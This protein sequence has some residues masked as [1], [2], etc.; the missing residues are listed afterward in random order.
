MTR[1]LD[2]P[3]SPAVPSTGGQIIEIAPVSDERGGAV[4]GKVDSVTVESGADLLVYVA[5]ELGNALSRMGFDVRQVDA[6]APVTDR[7]RVVAS[8]L[9]VDLSSESTLMFPVAAAVRLRIDVV[10]GSRPSDFRKEVRGAVSRELGFHKQGGPENAQLLAEAVQ[11]AFSMLEADQPFRAA[12]Q[13]SDR[14]TPTMASEQAP[15]PEGVA[16]RLATLDRLLAEGLINQDE[17]DRKR[18]EILDDL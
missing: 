6:N 8:L 10:D 15:P 2:M 12:L 3:N 1:V 5:G 13:G 7:K 14:K 18:R 17:Y 11:Q 9:S 4:L 16:D